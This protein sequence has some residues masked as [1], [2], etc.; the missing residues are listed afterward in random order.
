MRPNGRFQGVVTGLV[1]GLSFSPWHA[2]ED[3]RPLGNVMRARRVAYVHSAK[4]RQHKPEPTG[5]PLE[6]AG[7]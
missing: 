5:L 3:H 7:S 4:L 6:G 2:L 1:N